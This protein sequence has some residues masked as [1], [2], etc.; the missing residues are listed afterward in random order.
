MTD[1]FKKDTAHVEP[2][3]LYLHPGA[4][5]IASKP[6]IVSTVLGSCVSVCLWDPKLKIGG[7][8]HYML[9][10]WNGNGL[11]T[12]RYGN[13]AIDKLVEGMMNAGS[14]KKNIV[15]KVFGGAKVLKPKT[16]I[17]NIGQQ[18][19]DLAISELKNHG[20]RIVAESI[21]GTVG[22]KI[23]YFSHTGEVRQKYLDRNS[24]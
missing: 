19:I 18:N 9:P 13:I 24:N 20:I 1:Y 23:V 6:S 16:H 8:N 12:P 2:V 11:A 3:N 4:I 14:S 22:R 5:S 21:G 7:I 10:H 17:F 15:A